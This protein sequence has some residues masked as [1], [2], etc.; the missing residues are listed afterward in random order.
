MMANS[1]TTTTKKKVMSKHSRRNS[2]ESPT[3][4]SRTSA[5]MTIKVKNNVYPFHPMSLPMPPPDLRPWLIWKRKHCTMRIHINHTMRI[6]I[7][8]TMRIHINQMTLLLSRD[9]HS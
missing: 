2:Y 3:A 5:T 4:G 9:M 6:H 7:N 1:M 8:H